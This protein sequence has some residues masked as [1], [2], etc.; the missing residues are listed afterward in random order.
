MLDAEAILYADADILLALRAG[1]SGRR[2]RRRATTVRL[3]V[4]GANL[5][6]SP[7]AKEILHARGIPL[8]PDF[9]ANAGGIV[10]AAFSMDARLSPFAVKPDDIFHMVTEKLRANTEAV[11]AASQQPG[12]DP[13]RRRPADGRDPRRGS[14]AAAGPDHHRSRARRCR[15][16]GCLDRVRRRAPPPSPPALGAADAVNRTRPA[17]L[18][19]D[20]SALFEAQIQAR[21]LDFAGRWLQS[22]GQGFYTIGSAGHESNAVVAMACDPPTRRCSTTGP[23]VSSLLEPRPGAAIQIRSPTY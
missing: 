12:G 21:H 14:D 7:Q 22:Q 6:T 23:A 20:L 4:E 13:P 5:P 3:V 9:I 17:G 2:A 16:G 15:V 11:L 18:L 10:A 19:D 1:G 8:V